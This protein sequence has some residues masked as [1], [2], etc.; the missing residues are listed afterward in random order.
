V[1]PP[2]IA[3]C[4]CPNGCVVLRF[5]YITVH[6]PRATFLTFALRIAATVSAIERGVGPLAEH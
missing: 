4:N 1:E 5:A 3:L 6:L 2:T